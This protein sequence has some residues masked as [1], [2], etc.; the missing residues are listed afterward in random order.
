MSS[1][2]SPAKRKWFKSLG[3]KITLWYAFLFLFSSLMFSFFLYQLLQRQLYAEVDFFLNYEMSDF[4]Q[5]VADHQNNLS[6]IERQMQKESV[7]I[8]KDYQVFYG[9]LDAEKRVII[10]SSE[11]TLLDVKPIVVKS[12]IFPAADIKEYNLGNKKT[13]DAVRILTK[14]FE[15]ENEFIRYIQVGMNLTRIRKTLDNFRRNIL[16]ALPL[17]FIFSLGGGFILA[18][19]N[20][21]PL[22]QMITTASHITAFNLDERLPVRGAEDE[23]D[24][25]AQTFNDMIA[26]IKQAYEKLSQFSFDAAHEL[27]TPITAIIGEIE[28]VLSRRGSSEKYQQVLMSN[29][30][31]L[32]RLQKLVNHLLF[33]SQDPKATQKKNIE[34]IELN[35]IVRDIAELFEPVAKENTV[36]IT[37]KIPSDPI[38]F[39]AEK[40][41]IEQ[42]ISNLIDNAIRYNRPQG[43]IVIELQRKESVIEIIV[44]DTGVGISEEDKQKIFDRFYRG[45]PSRSR[46]LGGFGLGLSIV[47]SIVESYSGTVLVDSL[48]GKG[49]IFTVSLPAINNDSSRGTG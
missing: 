44:T 38:Y 20:L 32:S 43:N 10:Q 41:R 3:W 16:I 18:R 13:N 17:F 49:S 47:K 33:L 19:R 12:S 37:T 25:L 27:R 23:L 36:E 11:F 40:W 7:A 8:H 45:D 15:G 42:V 6:L 48:L 28:S 34:T 14:K 22:S 5:Y 30:E 39:H 24:R 4:S 35:E 21:K 31:E 29:L 9:I 26:R 46:S 1:K 2:K